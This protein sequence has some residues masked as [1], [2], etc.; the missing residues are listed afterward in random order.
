[1]ENGV[2]LVLRRMVE[3]L[4]KHGEEKHNNRLIAFFKNF[5]G[6]RRSNI[7]VCS[8][9]EFMNTTNIVSFSLFLHD[10]V[11]LNE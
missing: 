1:M 8:K 7:I 5:K 10:L 9:Y 4:R 6:S 3:H 2:P 11:E